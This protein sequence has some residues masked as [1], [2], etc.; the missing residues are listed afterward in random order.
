MLT[1]GIHS[2]SRR[3]SLRDRRGVAT[4]SLKARRPPG[5]ST[6]AHSSRTPALSGTCSSPS[7]LITAVKA[8]RAGRALGREIDGG[9]A[10]RAPGGDEAGRAGQPRAD[11][12][13]VAFRRD[14][15]PTRQGL[16]RGQSPVVIL[17]P[18]VEVVGGKPF[19]VLAL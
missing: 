16:H 9:D 10:G 12:E 17:V 13:H 3:R 11:V 7:W 18:F 8:S 4:Q 15:G 19:Q 14:G 1:A 5:R 2:S 6:R